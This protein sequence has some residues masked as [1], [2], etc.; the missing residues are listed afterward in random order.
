[1]CPQQITPKFHISTK[2]SKQIVS[3]QS[4]QKAELF[5]PPGESGCR[6]YFSLSGSVNLLLKQAHPHNTASG[7]AVPIRVTCCTVTRM[8]ASHNESASH[9]E[10][11]GQKE[12]RQK[13]AGLPQGLN[14]S[15]LFN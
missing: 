13:Q 10:Q 15:N 12:N 8:M 11:D 6:P 4:D 3:T 2:S 5:N 7:H 1:M 9:R 14:E